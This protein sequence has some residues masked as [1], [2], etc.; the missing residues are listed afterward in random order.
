[1]EFYGLII[2][3]LWY[4]L[5]KLRKH[6]MGG[7]NPKIKHLYTTYFKKFILNVDNPIK[8]WIMH[9]YVFFCHSIFNLFIYLFFKGV[10]VY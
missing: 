8:Y 5:L 10:T 2:S 7:K 9:Y 3:V 1:M 4:T 6:P